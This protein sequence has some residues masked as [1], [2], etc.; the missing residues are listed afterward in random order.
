MDE[1][2]EEWRRLAPAWIREARGGRFATREGVLDAPVLEACG[3]VAGQRALDSGCGEGRFCRILLERGA[4]AV[5]G[6]DRCEAMIEAAEA[7]RSK[8]DAYRVADVQDLSFLE[9]GSFDLAVSYLNHCDLPDADANVRE[10]FR[11]L[12]PGGRFVVANLHPMRSATGLWHRAADGA[13]EHV[14]LDRYFDEGARRWTILGTEITNFHRSLGATCDGFLR[15]GFRIDRIVE[16]SVTP[17]ALAR[18]PELDDELRVPN[19][20]VYAL[21]K[22]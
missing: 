9:D 12:A 22:P 16:P 19:F 13:K 4:R 10:V 8:G 11:V 14:L 18:F 17:E 15:A 2:A 5:L 21:G 3:E 20:I 1:L 7:L 6:L